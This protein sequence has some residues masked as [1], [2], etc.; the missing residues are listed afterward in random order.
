MNLLLAQ[1]NPRVGDLGANCDSISA[2]VDQACRGRVRPD[3][4]VCP[5]L[6]ICGYP[7]R[8]LLLNQGWLDACEDALEALAQSLRG[9]PPVLVGAPSRVECRGD[10]AERYPRSPLAYNS[11][12]L[13]HNGALGAR[14]HKSLLPEYDVFDETRYFAP[15][16]G[17]RALNISGASV[18]VLVC[19]DAWY[20]TLPAALKDRS[21][22]GDPV[23][24]ASC[25]GVSYW[26][27]MSASPF[28]AG[29]H[30]HRRSLYRSL[31]QRTGCPVAWV[32]QVGGNDGLIFD[33]GSGAC[34]KDG[35]F[36]A[37]A[38][39]FETSGLVIALPS[40]TA[41]TVSEGEAR[42][43]GTQRTRLEATGRELS[44]SMSCATL[45]PVANSLTRDEEVRPEVAW[46]TRSVWD[47][48]Q[49]GLEPAAER[50]TCSLDE[51]GAE[52][53]LEGEYIA[54]LTLG[55]RDFCHKTGFKQVL[56]G[57]SGGIDSA[58]VAVLAV[59]ALGPE[60]VR[61]FM[62]KSAFTSSASIED[63]AGLAQALGVAHETLSIERACDAFAQTLQPWLGAPGEAAGDDVTWENIQ[64]R[65]RGVILM[66]LANRNRALLLTTGNK[67][68][69]AVGY[70]T[71]YGDMSGALAVIADLWKTEVYAVARA[72]NRA[73]GCP[74]P[75][76][77]ITRPPSAELRPDQKD[78]DSLPDYAVL[79]PVL[80]SMVEGYASPGEVVKAGCSPELA[81]RAYALLCGAEHKRHQ[82]PPALVLSQRAFDRAWRVP[83]AVGS[84]FERA[85]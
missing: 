81:Y 44:E 72:L 27:C 74:I 16:R 42:M 78:S 68:E 14:I 65:C 5:E 57:L 69:I 20:A 63:A 9:G 66:A 49:P 55:L 22:D 6:S 73:P 61:T 24:H 2:A 3:L 71:L 48:P 56:V 10:A 17:A 52:N 31:A 53:S 77:I 11:A 84:P 54:A 34:R 47:P 1:L 21:L 35:S 60:H 76:R 80:R 39:R 12:V 18:G 45:V 62:L 29:K 51:G 82:L 30:Q 15:G 23:S 36:I 64:A 25:H 67:S 50:A 33:G 46:G 58:V 85:H 26:V 19:E 43:R 83:I 40:P 8:D 4:V 79:D 7:P 41:A 38:P 70:C 32:N 37:L 13:V 28:F 75:E 59:R